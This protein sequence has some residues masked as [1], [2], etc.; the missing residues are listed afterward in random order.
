MFYH[1]K[2]INQR[3]WLP[4]EN[5]RVMLVGLSKRDP[6]G[7]FQPGPLAVAGQFVWAPAEFTP[8]TIT[9]LREQVLDLGYVEENGKAFIPRLYAIPYNLQ[10]IGANE[11]MRFH[12]QIEAINLVSSIYVIEV[13][14]DGNWSYEPAT[15]RQHLPVRMIPSTAAP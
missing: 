13:A 14:W 11:A 1:L 15:M 7:I 5:C 3:G 8:P 10:C 2:V 12:L 4:A 9:L 6:S